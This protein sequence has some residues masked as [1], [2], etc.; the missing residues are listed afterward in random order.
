MLSRAIKIHFG[1]VV[2]NVMYGKTDNERSIN[3]SI[4]KIRI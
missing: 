3:K 1:H 4:Q 2:G